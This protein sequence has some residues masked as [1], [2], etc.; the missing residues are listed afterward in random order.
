LTEWLFD[1]HL[2]VNRDPRGIESLREDVPLIVAYSLSP[3]PSSSSTDT[4]P[5]EDAAPADATSDAP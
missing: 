5:A 2:R 4:L 3:L 1:F